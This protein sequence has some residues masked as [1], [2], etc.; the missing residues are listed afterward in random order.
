MLER[1]KKYG[2]KSNMGADLVNQILSLAQM[3]DGIEMKPVVS[4]NVKSYGYDPT[5]QV[6]AVVYSNGTEYRYLGVHPDYVDAISKNES[7]GR[8]INAVKQ[9]GNFFIKM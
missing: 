8:S 3:P 9:L 4:S 5:S 7:V 2:E 6:L 1:I